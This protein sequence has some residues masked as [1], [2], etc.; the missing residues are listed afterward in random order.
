MQKRLECIIT[1]RVQMVMFRDFTQRN[2]RKLGLVGEVK[3]MD[4]GSVYVVAEGEEE[5]L[6]NLFTLLHKGSIF[7]RVDSVEEKWM[8]P[9]GRFLEF[10]IIYS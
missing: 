3:N 1:G 9:V 8:K 10:N 2:A 6:R 4:D 5:K 7:A